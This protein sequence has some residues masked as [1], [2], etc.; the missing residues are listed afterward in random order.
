MRYKPSQVA[1]KTVKLVMLQNNNK[2][3]AWKEQSELDHIKHALMHLGILHSD[4]MT[5]HN[6]SE[7]HL[8]H[9]ITRLAMARA[10]TIDKTIRE[11]GTIEKA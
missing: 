2:G 9:A 10:I 7:D 4:I 6:S 1:K 5:S 11:G 8:A 3:D